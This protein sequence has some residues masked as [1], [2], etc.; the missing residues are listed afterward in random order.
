MREAKQA[1]VIEAAQPVLFRY[2]YR[3]VTMGDIAK[4]AGIS[5]PALY[6][7]FCNKEEVFAA[8]LEAFM[9]RTLA[10]LRE[11]LPAQ[12]TVS[13]K[14]RFAFEVWAVRPYT[15]LMASPDAKELIDCS[16]A[17]AKDTLE[18]GQAAFEAELTGILAP[19]AAQAPGPALPPEQI[20]RILTRAVHGF[21]ESAA[22]VEHLRTLIDGLLTMVL[23]SFP[24]GRRA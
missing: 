6:L 17:F 22:S 7:L 11:G 5:R 8:T 20:A 18:Q 24:A 2:G 23:A 1:R 15:L 9:A 3:R 13:G 19:L 12:D 16:F 21:K 4:A 14:L 10:E